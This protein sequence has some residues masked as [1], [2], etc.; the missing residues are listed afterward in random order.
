MTLIFIKIIFKILTFKIL[1]QMKVK[2]ENSFKI[3]KNQELNCFHD[4]TWKI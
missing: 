1:V 3:A 4:V 2:P